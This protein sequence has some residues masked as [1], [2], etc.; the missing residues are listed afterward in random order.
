[1]YFLCLLK[2]REPTCLLLIYFPASGA[3]YLNLS[4]TAQFEGLLALWWYWMSVGPRIQRP[5]ALLPGWIYS[6][7]WRCSP[8]IVYLWNIWCSLRSVMVLR[9]VMILI[10]GAVFAVWSRYLRIYLAN[11]TLVDQSQVVCCKVILGAALRLS[12]EALVTFPI[13]WFRSLFAGIMSVC[14]IPHFPITI[15]SKS[16]YNGLTLG[17]LL[18]LLFVIALKLCAILINLLV[19]FSLNVLEGVLRQ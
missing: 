7:R 15:K 5:P 8:Y 16:I 17:C 10:H 9:L 2:H 19:D 12:S 11:D 3:T 14:I 6:R 1:M 4:Q 18:F 13:S